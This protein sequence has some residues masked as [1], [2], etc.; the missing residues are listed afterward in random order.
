MRKETI[1]KIV[2]IAKIIG[3]DT[4][5]VKDLDEFIEQ[6]HKFIKS[7]STKKIDTELELLKLVQGN[8]KLEEPF[9][10]YL[11]FKTVSEQ[12]YQRGFEDA[13]NLRKQEDDKEV[14]EKQK[15]LVTRILDLFEKNVLPTISRTFTLM[16]GMM[17]QNKI[18]QQNNIKIKF[19]E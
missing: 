10:S 2:E 5:K 17:Q 9:R 13:L 3:L 19:E 11:L 4:E 6:L 16:N 7:E 8:Q 12:M 1:E 14:R 15:Q 18:K